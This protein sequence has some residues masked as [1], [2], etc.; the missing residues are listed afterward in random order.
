M[1]NNRQRPTAVGSGRARRNRYLFGIRGSEFL[2]AYQHPIPSASP[3]LQVRKSNR[4]SFTDAGW[5]ARAGERSEA[6]SIVTPQGF[7]SPKRY[8][9]QHARKRRRWRWGSAKDKLEGWCC[10]DGRLLRGPVPYGVL[11]GR[12]QG[13]GG[14]APAPGESQGGGGEK[15]WMEVYWEIACDAESC[16]ILHLSVPGGT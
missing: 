12:G 13:F 11:W 10:N 7:H 8:G 5:G 3:L 15:G 2:R 16:R 9:Q 6:R 14:G 1:A 4:C